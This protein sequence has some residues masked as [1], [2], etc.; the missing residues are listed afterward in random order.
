MAVTKRSS[1]QELSRQLA[2][3]RREFLRTGAAMALGGT[4]LP[5]GMAMAGRGALA[6]IPT[7]KR[8][9]V[10]I[11]FGGG[12]RD[13][14]TFAPEGQENIPHLMRELIPQSTFF[15]QVVNRGILGHYVATAS[16][17]T[18]VYEPGYRGLRDDQQFCFAST[19][20][21]HRFRVLSQRFETAFLGRLGSGSEQRFQS[22][23]GEQSSRVRARSGRER[24]SAE[25]FADRGDVG[26]HYRLRAF[27]AR[28]LR[29]SAVRAG[30]G[31]ERISVAAIGDDAE[32]FGRRLQGACADVVEP[33]RAV[34]VYRATADAPACAQP[35][36]DHH[37]RHRYRAR[38]RVLAVH[39]RHSPH[40][41]A[42]R[43]GVEG[44]PKRAGIRRQ[45]HALHPAGFWS[46]LG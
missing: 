19:G 42:L 15:T 32:A 30:P 22:H 36:V 12:A 5:S 31:R 7:K 16:L 10:V 11:T 38:R 4:L 14:E 28:Q 24:D 29:K 25:T 1:P 43:R 20:A 6:G 18:G 40:G 46:R 33:G 8:K 45:H 26:P 13:Q 35:A 39:R 34:G 3:S 9:V 17:A 27:A 37:A 2:W 23:R 41:P 44:H 21:S